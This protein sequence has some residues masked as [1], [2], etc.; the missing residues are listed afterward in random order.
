MAPTRGFEPRTN[1]LTVDRSTAELRGNSGS[2]EDNTTLPP[3]VQDLL[4]RLRERCEYVFRMVLRLHFVENVSYNACVIHNK[5]T[6]VHPSIRTPVHALFAPDCVLRRNYA[7]D[8]RKQNERKAIFRDP[9]LLIGGGIG[10]DT[11]EA[12]ACVV[13]LRLQI[14]EGSCFECSTTRIDFREKEQ[15]KA[16]R[17]GEEIMQAVCYSVGT[18][19]REIRQWLP[20]DRERAICHKTCVLSRAVQPIQ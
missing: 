4:C 17:R 6:S 8:I 7:A 11:D 12:I 20:N 2:E 5:R 1:R 3:V 18:R 19:E 15:H 10:T 13:E 14:T 16:A 9:L